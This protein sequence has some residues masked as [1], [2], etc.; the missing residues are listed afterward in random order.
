[1]SFFLPGKQVKNWLECEGKIMMFSKRSSKSLFKH[2]KKKGKRKNS[3]EKH[4]NKENRWSP[5]IFLW[6]GLTTRLIGFLNICT[7]RPIFGKINTFA[8]CASQQS[9]SD[10]ALFT[11]CWVNIWRCPTAR[12]A[13]PYNPRP[14]STPT[15]FDHDPVPSRSCH[16]RT[17]W[18]AMLLNATGFFFTD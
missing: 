6:L 9:S 15:Q 5:P 14:F 17:V 3:M 2:S 11:S 16:T 7:R 10:V 18:S 1:M 4:Q 13:H 12:Q 8:C